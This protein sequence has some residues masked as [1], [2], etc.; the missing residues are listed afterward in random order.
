MENKDEKIMLSIIVPVYNTLHDN[1]LN[2]CIESLINQTIKDKYKYEIICI[3]DCSTDGS[4]NYLLDIQKK[5]PN[6]IKVFRQTNNK[7]QGA[8]RNLGIKYSNGKYLTFMDSDDFADPEMYLKLINNAINTGADV[9]AS[10]I[11]ITT[12]QKFKTGYYKKCINIELSGN[13]KN[14]VE[15]Q[16]KLIFRGPSPNFIFLSKIV[17]ENNLIQPENILYEDSADSYWMYYFNKIEIVDEY[18]Y[19]HYIANNNSTTHKIYDD[20]HRYDRY[21]SPFLLID[22]TKNR[23]IYDK[24]SDLYDYKVFYSAEVRN[25]T[26]FIENSS[27]KYK[28][29]QLLFLKN[30]L[31]TIWNKLQKNNYYIEYKLGNPNEYI[32]KWL[33]NMHMKNISLF[34]ILYYLTHFNELVIYILVRLSGGRAYNMMR[35]IKYMSF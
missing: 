12:K 5:C 14:N 10:Q 30:K 15:L 34:L 21:I 19:Y 3:D 9:V 20:K 32:H 22:E 26:L 8:A 6:L 27:L 25:K 4:Y 31:N 28:Y 13:L 18:L 29:D 17:K 16:K 1:L 35:K 23:N 24:Y 11:I 7:K 2:F 33:V